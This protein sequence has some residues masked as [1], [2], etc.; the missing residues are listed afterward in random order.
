MSFMAPEVHA[1]RQSSMSVDIWS[2]GVVLYHIIFGYLPFE[3]SSVEEI[4]QKVLNR[5]FS[6][7]KLEQ[8]KTSKDLRDLLA[9]MFDK[10]PKTR[11]T[12]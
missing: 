12:I 2:L 9:Q 3:G 6:F 4:K 8:K 5:E 1:N 10:N 11:I 7:S